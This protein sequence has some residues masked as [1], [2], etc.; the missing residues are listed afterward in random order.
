MRVLLSSR[1][2]VYAYYLER[3]GYYTARLNGIFTTHTHDYY[4]SQQHFSINEFQNS[5]SKCIY[6]MSTHVINKTGVGISVLRW[7]RLAE[8]WPVIELDSWNT[9][10]YSSVYLI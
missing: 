10:P 1:C 9:A 6:S 5:T 3:L 4:V 7:T 2:I 8:V